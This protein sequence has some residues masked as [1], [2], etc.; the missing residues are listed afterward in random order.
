MLAA[1]RVKLAG[2]LSL[3][4]VITAVV[5]SGRTA[6]SRRTPLTTFSFAAS[7]T[8]LPLLLYH[9]VLLTLVSCVDWMPLGFVTGSYAPHG[10]AGPASGS[11]VP[12]LGKKANR[13]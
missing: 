9:A 6:A 7:C 2:G 10:G 13:N 4:S 12:N 5:Q 3:S 1:P 11:G 8:G